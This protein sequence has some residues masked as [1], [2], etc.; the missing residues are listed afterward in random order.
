[1]NIS[2]ATIGWAGVKRNY[3]YCSYGDREGWG[4]RG[5]KRRRRKWAQWEGQVEEAAL[6][7]SLAI[8]MRDSEVAACT[9]RGV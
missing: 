4:Q 3:R 7:D 5:S 8:G 6:K 9:Q 2:L 1:M